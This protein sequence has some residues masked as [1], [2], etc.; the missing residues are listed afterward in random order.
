MAAGWPRF[1]VRSGNAVEQFAMSLA[2]VT[3]SAKWRPPKPASPYWRD[4][5]RLCAPEQVVELGVDV[6]V[7]AL[8]ASG[9]DLVGPA[10]EG[11]GGGA[12]C[13]KVSVTERGG[14]RDVQQLATVVVGRPDLD[15]SLT[16]R[17]FKA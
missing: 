14:Q 10:Q 6:D 9:D 15:I 11:C 3:R 4:D 17:P 16:G 1:V 8:V 12:R 7:L 13:L 5:Y 2:E